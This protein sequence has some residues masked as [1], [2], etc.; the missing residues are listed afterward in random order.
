MLGID[1]HGSALTARDETS[2]FDPHLLFMACGLHGALR[3]CD[4]AQRPPCYDP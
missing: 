1:S 2:S 3:Q 4:R